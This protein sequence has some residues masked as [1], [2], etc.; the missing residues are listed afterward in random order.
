MIVHRAVFH[1]NE[2]DALQCYSS[3]RVVLTCCPA[4]QGSPVQHLVYHL[5]PVAVWGVLV[6]R[7]LG[8]V[9][10][11]WLLLHHYNMIWETAIRILAIF[12]GVQILVSLERTRY[13]KE[14][15]WIRSLLLRRCS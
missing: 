5:L 2:I 7:W 4:V 3:N 12:I 1:L 15:W 9:R 8:V 13:C 6:W 14:R 11:A 10:V